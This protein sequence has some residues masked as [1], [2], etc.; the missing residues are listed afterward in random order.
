M[1]RRLDLH[2]MTTVVVIVTVAI[3]M[4]SC[5]T[6][7]APTASPTAAPTAAPRTPNAKPADAATTALAIKG[8]FLPSDLGA[9]WKVQKPASVDKPDP[10]DCGSLN[11]N[12][13]LE[14]P[15]GA[16]QLGPQMS[17]G[18]TKWWIS[19]SATVF[20]NEAD[21][22]AWI[23]LRQSDAYVECRRK[24]IED[25]QR[26]ADPHWSVVTRER[27][28]PGLGTSGFEAFTAYVP[29]FDDGKGAKDANGS[30]DRFAYRVGRVV[31]LLNRDIVTGT[32]DPAHISETVTTDINRA[33]GNVYARLPAA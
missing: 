14:L 26:T 31:V 23:K 12:I 2:R 17:F 32:T 1:S 5:G 9:A 22:K 28:A 30:F 21:A 15:A 16:I 19:S 27:S 11:N 7:A 18:D 13:L 6:T 20:A 24:Q 33:L 29:Q 4:A 3:T 10:G 25:Y 8:T